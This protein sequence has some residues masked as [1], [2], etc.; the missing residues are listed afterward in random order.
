MLVEF[1]SSK[2]LL[3]KMSKSIEPHRVTLSGSIVM[4]INFIQI[5]LKY[6][7]SIRMNLGI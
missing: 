4:R 1:D 2:L 5:G 7:A 3:L 6:F